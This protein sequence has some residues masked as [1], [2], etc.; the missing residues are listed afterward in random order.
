MKSRP[1]KQLKIQKIM[2][3][4]IHHGSIN[5]Y[6]KRVAW[7]QQSK[8][9]QHKFHRKLIIY[10]ILAAKIIQLVMDTFTTQPILSYRGLKSFGS[11]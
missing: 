8:D 5:E 7:G 3:P 11:H 9:I 10:Y 2:A 1:L 6:Q 4:K